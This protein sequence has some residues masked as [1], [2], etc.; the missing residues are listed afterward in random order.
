MTVPEHHNQAA[1]V[2]VAASAVVEFDELGCI[3]ARRIAVH[4]VDKHPVG[5][6]GDGDGK[7]PCEV[8]HERVGR[9]VAVS[10][11]DGRAMERHRTRLAGGEG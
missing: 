1:Q 8:V 7:T 2:G 5:R 10:I 3:T 11:V 9:I 6:R 4:F